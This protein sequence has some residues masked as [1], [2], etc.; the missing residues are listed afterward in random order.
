MPIKQ[1]ATF[2][3]F[4]LAAFEAGGY[5][6]QPNVRKA[7]AKAERLT[8]TDRRTAGV[9]HRASNEA[10]GFYCFCQPPRQLNLFQTI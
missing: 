10:S 2:S 4:L 3:C 6:P 1:S 7:V 8:A 5:R 9:A